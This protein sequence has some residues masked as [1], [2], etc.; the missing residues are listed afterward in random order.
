MMLYDGVGEA[1][2]MGIVTYE[3]YYIREKSSKLKS[4]VGPGKR[5]H[6]IKL[7]PEVY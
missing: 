5:S 2:P 4:T 7:K 1:L 6:I 3:H